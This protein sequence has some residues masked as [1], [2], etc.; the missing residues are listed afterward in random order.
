M[1]YKYVSIPLCKGETDIYP[2][3]EKQRQVFIYQQVQ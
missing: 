3:V 2:P 1:S